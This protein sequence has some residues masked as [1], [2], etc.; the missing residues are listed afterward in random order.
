VAASCTDGVKDGTETDVDCGG[1]TCSP[2]PD[3]DTCLLAG[4][5][6]DGVCSGNPLTCQAPTCTDGVKNGSETDTD[7]GGS[8]NA[9]GKT[10]PPSKG[11]ASNN[12]CS[13]PGVCN[14]TDTCVVGTGDACSIN[15]DCASDDCLITLL[16]L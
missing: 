6:T 5:C 16:C 14:A 13:A 1:A 9:L 15:S 10:C 2:C 8:C 7:C 12:D 11:C 4:D 3:N